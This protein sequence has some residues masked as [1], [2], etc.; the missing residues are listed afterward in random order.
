ML[1]R[2]ASP[3]R[4][5]GA[6]HGPGG[7]A[8]PLRE[9]AARLYDGGAGAAEGSR[10]AAPHGAGHPHP[11]RPVVRHQGRQPAGVVGV[12]VRDH[13]RV[14][15]AYSEP[16]ERR[17]HRALGAGWASID[18]SC[19]CAAAQHCGVALPHVDEDDAQGRR[20]A[21]HARGGRGPGRRGGLRGLRASRL[22]GGRPRRRGGRGRSALGGRAAATARH[23][24]GEHHGGQ[25]S[26]E[27]HAHARDGPSHRVTLP[28]PADASFPAG[29]RLTARPAGHAAVQ[30]S[31]RAGTR[32]VNRR[33]EGE[34]CPTHPAPPTPP[35]PPTPAPPSRRSCAGCRRPSCTC[36]SRARSSPSC[37]WSSAAATASLFPAPQPRSVAPNTASTTS[38]TSWTSTTRAS[39]SS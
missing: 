39:P 11:S 29:R 10:E 34:P 12:Q 32:A 25:R 24:G 13:E 15:A 28:A 21:G 26:G 23:P 31:R 4:P 19:P 8:E 6:D 37:C 7:L 38:S 9:A 5:P 27:D 17:L 33:P 35:L 3:L 36:T 30:R 2:L 22:G 18:E 1:S 16:G 14:E 20:P